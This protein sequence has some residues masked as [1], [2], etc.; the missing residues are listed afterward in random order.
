MSLEETAAEKRR[1]LKVSRMDT[2][3]TLVTWEAQK[4]Y[5]K[6]SQG[7]R[8]SRS[9]LSD[10]QTPSTVYNFADRIARCDSRT[11]RL[12]CLGAQR[13]FRNFLIHS[14]CWQQEHRCRYTLK[15]YAMD[16]TLKFFRIFQTLKNFLKGG[17]VMSAKTHG[18]REV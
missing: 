11:I 12:Q 4:C 16:R 6:Y 17:S 13:I 2:A 15:D 3:W 14:Y 1:P 7:T 5:R 18:T 10:T 9:R 8:P